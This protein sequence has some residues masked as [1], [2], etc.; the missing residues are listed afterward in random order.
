MQR[1]VL[2]DLLHRAALGAGAVLGASTRITGA[3][4]TGE[5][6]CLE[7]ENGTVGSF[8]IVLDCLVSRSVL[9]PQPAAPLRYGA[10]WAL[11]DW[12]TDAGFDETALAQRYHAASRMAG[13]LPV[14]RAEPGAGLKATFFW[15]LR[16]PDHADWRDAALERWKTQVLELWPECAP[17]LDQ[18]SDHE[19]LAFARY[20]HRTLGRPVSPR[21]AHLGDS[22]RA[23]SPQLG[24]GANMALLDAMALAVAFRSAPDPLAALERYAA[25]RRWHVRLYQGA[26]WLLTPV[27]QSDS[28]VLPFLRDRAMGPLA[29]LWPISTLLAALVSGR[30]GRPLA[31]LGLEWP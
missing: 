28:R 8:D 29:R 16:G 10:L 12:P 22:Y 14:G 24:Q 21:I 3:E 11:L 25:L 26:S 4:Q 17:L 7:A 13:V 18:I 1:A 30:V 31:G 27:Y 20:T 5:G 15:S 19:Q 6:V 23:T 2:F 9:C